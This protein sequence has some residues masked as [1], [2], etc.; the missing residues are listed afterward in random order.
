VRRFL[1]AVVLLVLPRAV[2]ASE[3]GCPAHVSVTDVT[4]TYYEPISG[5]ACSLPTPPGAFYAA[6]ASSEYAGSEICGRCVRVT[7]PEGAIT[8]QIVDECVDPIGCT[9][10]HLDLM[11]QAAF[12]AIGDPLQGIVPIT[13]ETVACDVGATTMQLQFQGSNAYYLKAQVQ[14]HR[15]GVASVEMADGPLWIG[16]TRTLDDHFERSAGGPF[17]LPYVFRI[18]DVHGQA[19]TT[20]LVASLVN[21]VPI[22]TGVQFATCPEPDAA[23]GSGAAAALVAALRAARR[24]APPRAAP[25]RSA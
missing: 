21:D 18:T 20:D 22:D 5:G 6:I 13:W 10:G 11:G 9:S 1:L 4:A 16:M 19:V 7:G 12:D 2:V 14:N 17:V 3:V 23:L 8:A 25:R 15:Y 24:R